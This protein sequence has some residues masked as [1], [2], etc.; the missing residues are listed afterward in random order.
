MA[1]PRPRACAH[2]GPAARRCSTAPAHGRPNARGSA[3]SAR[4]AEA[5]G[6]QRS[7]DVGDSAACGCR[8]PRHRCRTTGRTHSRCT[9]T[10]RR[11]AAR[12][13][14]CPA[15]ARAAG[16]RRASQTRSRGPTHARRRLQFA[17]S[18][19]GTCVRETRNRVGRNRVAATKDPPAPAAGP[20]ASSASRRAAAPFPTAALRPRAYQPSPAAATTRC[21]RA[22]TRP[23]RRGRGRRARCHR[24]RRRA[25]ALGPP[26]LPGG[27]RP[28]LGRATRS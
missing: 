27:R 12:L 6:P 15:R 2:R 1:G 20:A 21:A 23:P 9:G 3:A 18:L 10:G 11:G 19:K 22:P 5:C 16:T 26:P 8:S 4:A 17:S 25:G 28:A 13:T 7:L 24:G 14:G